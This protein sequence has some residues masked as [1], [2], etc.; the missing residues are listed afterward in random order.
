MNI[1]SALLV[2]LFMTVSTA[3]FGQVV[4]DA[5]GNFD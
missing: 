1:K 2:P 4:N 5:D 3:T